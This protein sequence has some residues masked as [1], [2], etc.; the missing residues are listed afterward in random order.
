[1]FAPSGGVTGVRALT[2]DLK[3]SY[4]RILCHRRIRERTPPS[5]GV[6]LDPFDRFDDMDEVEPVNRSQWHGLPADAISDVPVQSLLGNH[7]NPAAEQILQVLGER[8]MV[9]EAPPRLELDGEVEVACWSLLA[10]CHRTEDPDRAGAVPD[11]DLKD[12]VF[13]F[14]QFSM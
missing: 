14:E 8:D 2:D 3:V 6:V 11:R 5:P 10:P 4:H 7:V 13:S 1:M 12:F 9:E